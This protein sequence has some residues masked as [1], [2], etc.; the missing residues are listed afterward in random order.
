MYNEL[1]ESIIRTSGENTDYLYDFADR[2]DNF[3]APV[4]VIEQMF[5]RV[6]REIEITRDTLSQ[7]L[8]NYFEEKLNV[9]VKNLSADFI[10]NLIKQIVHDLLEQDKMFHNDQGFILIP[11]EGAKL[12][13]GADQLQIQA[14][15][16]TVIQVCTK[17]AN[18]M[19]NI[20]PNEIQQY[21]KTYIQSFSD[22]SFN[23]S[24]KEEFRKHLTNQIAISKPFFIKIPDYNPASIRA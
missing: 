1:F 19:A 9:E 2:A 22:K 20:S 24:W 8:L 6:L 21:Q 5:E 11:S 4:P 18:N 7:T 12:R 17:T 10:Q 3:W 15:I 23:P 16:D 13:R 14:F